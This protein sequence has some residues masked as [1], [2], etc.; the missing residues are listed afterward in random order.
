MGVHVILPKSMLEIEVKNANMGND[1]ASLSEMIENHPRPTTFPRD[2]SSVADSV[3][4]LMERHPTLF[5]PFV[6][7]EEEGD[8]ED[9]SENDDDGY[10]SET[11]YHLPLNDIHEQ[12]TITSPPSKPDGPRRRRRISSSPLDDSFLLLNVGTDG[13]SVDPY[14]EF[15]DFDDDEDII[16]FPTFR[17]AK[18]G[19]PAMIDVPRATP[20]I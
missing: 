17:V 9:D 15:D 12:T 18:A 6:A 1:E 14:D 20:C 16:D 8:N 11:E 13:C 7:E 19:P 2:A 10:F 4:L 5:N 3:D